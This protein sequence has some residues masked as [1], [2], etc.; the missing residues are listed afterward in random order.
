MW[1]GRCTH[2]ADGMRKFSAQR[3]SESNPEQTAVEVGQTSGVSA[4]GDDDQRDRVDHEKKAMRLDRAGE[5]DKF[6]VAGVPRA[7]GCQA[8]NG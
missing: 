8:F 6:A 2:T 7:K 1:V 4:G 3:V 5:M